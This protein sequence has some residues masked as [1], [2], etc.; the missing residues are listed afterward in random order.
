MR[1]LISQCFSGMKECFSGGQIKVVLV[2]V[3][4]ML[5]LMIVTTAYA[6]CNLDQQ[7]YNSCLIYNN[8]AQGQ[9]YCMDI[10]TTCY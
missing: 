9:A 6:Y 5:A 8:T 2:C 10:C 7:C 4:I 1:K 3:L